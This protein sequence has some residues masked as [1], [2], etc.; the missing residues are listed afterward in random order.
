MPVGV[1]DHVGQ[2]GP[3]IK[4]Q[5]QNSSSLSCRA[6]EDSSFAAKSVGFQ[7]EGNQRP[8]C[9]AGSPADTA[10][11]FESPVNGTENKSFSCSLQVFLPGDESP[12]DLNQFSVCVEIIRPSS[13]PK[14]VLRLSKKTFATWPAPVARLVEALQATSNCCELTNN[15]CTVCRRALS[16]LIAA[17]CQ[18]RGWS[19]KVS[20]PQKMPHRFGQVFTPTVLQAS[21]AE[22]E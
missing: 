3:Q 11:D 8:L 21:T 22:F 14:A 18:P 4:R 17:R 13:N 5:E 15:C 20:W 12:F 9:A 6:N 2:L 16:L 1:F 10:C 7:V 19:L